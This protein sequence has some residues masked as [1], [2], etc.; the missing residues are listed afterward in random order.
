MKK[1]VIASVSLLLFCIASILS[2]FT[3]GGYFSSSDGGKVDGT[4]HIGS[5]TASTTTDG[6]TSGGNDNTPTPE[7]DK[8]YQTNLKTALDCTDIEGLIKSRSAASL[9]SRVELYNKLAGNVSEFDAKKD[10]ISASGVYDSENYSVK[11]AKKG[12]YDEYTKGT[13]VVT[14]YTKVHSPLDGSYDTHSHDE[15]RARCKVVPYMGYLLVSEMDESGE[16]F[17]SLCDYEG[18]A[19]I[20]DIGDK[21][22]YY[23]RN[24]DNLPVFTDQ[25][26]QYYSFDGEKFTSIKRDTIR[27]ELYYDYPASP[28]AKNDGTTEVKYLSNYDQYRFVNYKTGKNFFSTRYLYAFNFSE[29]YAVIMTTGNAARII[30]TS[31]K[32]VFASTAW[33]IF[34][35]TKMYVQYFFALP[36]TLGIES[37]GSSGFD[38]GWL[39]IRVRALSRMS[40][41]YDTIADD[42]DRLINTSGEYFDIPA[43]YTLE[44]YSNGILLLSKDGL[45]GYYSIKGY[46]IAQPIFD[47]ARPFIQGLAV[48]GYADG[49]V[50]MID[51]EGNI[52][53]PFVYTHISD[54]SSGIIT[55]YTEGIGW[56]VY[57]LCEEN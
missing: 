30:N 7:T 40:T 3:A 56:N 46:W 38:N 36:D 1:T 49:T 28:L 43:G 39:R 15:I 12:L 13:E 9:E 24:Y 2:I 16:M 50:G 54:V 19:I 8:K 32:S 5:G 41:T 23:A 45:Y 26:S 6:V 4:T 35:G 53:L 33:K 11:L 22:P 27:A 42:V 31:G 57:C 29:G 47:Y 25:R 34:P 52:V 17:I 37:I 18:N 44:G 55:A 48:V 51:T 20:A 10:K 21:T 14:V